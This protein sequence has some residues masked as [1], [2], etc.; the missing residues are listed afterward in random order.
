MATPA[1]APWPRL[2][3]FLAGVLLA[4]CEAARVD[5]VA[6]LGARG[7]VGDSEFAY[8]NLKLRLL[9][10]HGAARK[11]TEDMAALF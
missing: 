1:E 7:W 5:N 8:L 2:E 11:N 3:L 6:S 4:G 9:P 10:C